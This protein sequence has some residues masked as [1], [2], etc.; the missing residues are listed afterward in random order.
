MTETTK[1]AWRD[2]ARAAL[3]HAID[4]RWG[5]ARDTLQQLA[6]EHGADVIPSCLLAW[7]DTMLKHAYPSRQ[8]GDPVHLG[9]VDVDGRVGPRDPAQRWAG[10][11]IS[12]R[13]AD[14]EDT[15][16]DLVASVQSGQGWSEVVWQVL[17]LCGTTIRVATHHG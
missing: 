3:Q 9:I 16:W 12:A 1:C 2:L 4:S 14:D 17:N 15:F 6:D 11:A 10:W 8:P 5:Q 7:I 13:A